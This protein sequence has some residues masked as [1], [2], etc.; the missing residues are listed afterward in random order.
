LFLANSDGTNRL[1]KRNLKY[2]SYRESLKQR[3]ELR[4]IAG[5]MFDHPED[6]NKKASVTKETHEGLRC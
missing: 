1:K 3:A 2:V 4:N 6:A 5:E